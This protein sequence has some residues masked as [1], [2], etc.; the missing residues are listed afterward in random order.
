M[1]C[2]NKNVQDI[3]SIYSKHDDQFKTINLANIDKYNKLVTTLFQ[4]Y[5]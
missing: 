5:I 2:S 1:S 3:E 4:F